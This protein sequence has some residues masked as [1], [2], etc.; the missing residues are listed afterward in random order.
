MKFCPVV[1]E[2]CHGQ[3]HM[4]KKER[5]RKRIIIIII[6]RNEAKTISLPKLFGRLNN[7]Q[8]VIIRWMDSC[9]PKEEEEEIWNNVS[10]GHR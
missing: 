7:K 2:I 10:I 5:R 3:I 9:I 8:L 6:R 4:P 1:A